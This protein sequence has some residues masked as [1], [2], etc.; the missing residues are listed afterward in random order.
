MIATILPGSTNFHAVSY[1]E[2]KVSTG[3]AQRIEMKNFGALGMLEPPTPGELTSFFQ[4]YSDRNK[5]ITKAQFH[6]A[7]S[8]KGHEM[9]ESEILEFA[10]EWLREMGYMEPGQPLLAY[11][12]RDTDNTH[13]HIITSRVAPDGR[14]IEHD[15]E[16]RRS[17]EVVDRL[18]SIN[19]N[20]K[21]EKDIASSFFYHFGSMAQYKAV[22]NSLGYEVYNKEGKVFIKFGGKI[23]KKIDESEITSRLENTKLNKERCRQLRSILCKYR[24]RSSDIEELKG[25]LKKKFGID[26]VFFGKKDNPF[27]YMLIDHSDKTVINGNRILSL[28][29]LMDFATQEER[30]DRMESFIEELLR[31]TPTLSQSDI[32]EALSNFHAWMKKGKLHYNGASR[33]LKPELVDTIARNNRIRWIESFNPQSEAER[34]ILC[35]I[36]KVKVEGEIRNQI[37]LGDP[38]RLKYSEALSRLKEIADDVSIASI[39]YALYRNNFVIR[40]NGEETFAIDFSNRL[41]I[42]LTSIGF[43][44]DDIQRRHLEIRRELFRQGKRQTEAHPG[45]SKG[46]ARNQKPKGPR[47]VGGGSHYQN[48]EWEVGGNDDYDRVD[49]HTTLKR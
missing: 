44:I 17:Q 40:Q 3:S 41:I 6:V 10:H 12:H 39:R 37:M 49:D 4:G 20:E 35:E 25:H 19:R 47:D 13:I 48:R 23:R 9:S 43:D 14:K 26:L 30:L 21:V 38:S 2:H 33:P 34:D 11:A 16:R 36:G 32:H 46:T 8:C 24:D 5:R 18:M 45:E 7:F 15:H 22:M 29:R 31:A 1:N 42:N 27:G 28:D